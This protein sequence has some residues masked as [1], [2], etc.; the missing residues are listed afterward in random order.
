MQL[1]FE[2]LEVTRVGRLAIREALHALMS[3]QVRSMRLT[4]QSQHR[5]ICAGCGE[6]PPGVD[7]A[8]RTYDCHMTCHAS[9]DLCF[10]MLLQILVQALLSDGRREGDPAHHDPSPTAKAYQNPFWRAYK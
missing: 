7:E 1:R 2:C 10:R 5:P 8:A 6:T 3:W 4:V 9:P